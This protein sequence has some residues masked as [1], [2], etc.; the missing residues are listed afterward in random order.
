MHKKKF[1]Y[2]SQDNKS[3]DSAKVLKT[4]SNNTHN[5]QSPFLNVSY[6]FQINSY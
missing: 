2:K 1:I 5:L 3:L 6:V 4:K